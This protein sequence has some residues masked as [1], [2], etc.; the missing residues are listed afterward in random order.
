M[1]RTASEESVLNILWDYKSQD[2]EDTASTNSMVRK[3]KTAIDTYAKDAL[4][5][6]EIR[7]ATLLHS[8]IDF[9]VDERGKHYVAYAILAYEDAEDPTAFLA[10]LA[11]AWLSYLLFPVKAKGTTKHG[12]PSTRQTPQ[13][14][15][16]AQLIQSASRGDQKAFRQ[17]LRLRQGDKCPITERYGLDAKWDI[18]RSQQGLQGATIACHIL[19]FSLNDFQESSKSYKGAVVTWTMIAAWCSLDVEKLAGSKIN[20]P[21]NGLLLRADVD[22]MFSKFNL[23]FEKTNR[24][25][26]YTVKA[27]RIFTEYADKVVTFTNEHSEAIDLP[28]PQILELHA[29]FSRVFHMSGA[30]EYFEAYWRDMDE[31][32]VL[33]PDGSTNFDFML[34]EA[35][36][37]AQVAVN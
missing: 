26:T 19:P 8:L 6:K 34:V 10:Q 7:V 12:I 4:L 17:L 15:E 20:G 2:L 27:G 11:E 30:G 37:A 1:E 14:E 21:S 23:W 24:P 28:D 16:I 32:R 25:N 22:P 29:A 31:I 9:A 33:A 36:S 13:I 18:V 3:A 5:H 35:R